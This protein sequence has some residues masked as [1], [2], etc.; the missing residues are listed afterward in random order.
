MGMNLDVAVKGI[1]K[2]QNVLTIDVPPKLRERHSVGMKW[3]D[4]ALGGGGFTPGTVTMITGTPG[5][6]KT[7]LFM[8]MANELT[9][10]GHH[11]LL[12]T[13][14]ESLYQV[15]LV[16]E[17]LKMTNG[18]L[19]GQDIMLPKALLHCK[20]IMDEM[21]PDQ[22]DGTVHNI[23]IDKTTTVPFGRLKVGSKQLFLLIDSLQ[24]MDDGF[25]A[26]SKG[27][28]RG[29]NAMTPVRVI[30]ALTNFAKTTFVNVIFIGQVNKTGEFAGK[31]TIK[32]AVDSHG[33]LFI[34]MQKNSD[35][36]GKRMFVM[37]KNRFGC[38]GRTYLIGMDQ[39]GLYELGRFHED[40]HPGML[41]A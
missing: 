12:N 21:M 35:Y 15:K 41:V 1:K 2:G 25:Y 13:G 38:A 22:L 33:H 4:D 28:S 9:G 5:A 3:V 27:Q 30:E 18:F 7:T 31:M 8:Q 26:D 17:R 29:T 24:V 40:E 34:D 36:Y 16:S 10:M 6:G 20:Y 19:A 11:A 23:A 14:E 39:R 32:H 37:S